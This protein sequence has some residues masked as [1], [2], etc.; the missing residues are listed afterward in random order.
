VGQRNLAV[1]MA[2]FEHIPHFQQEAWGGIVGGAV[3]F[4]GNE[5]ERELFMERQIRIAANQRVGVDVRV[6]GIPSAYQESQG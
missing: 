5:P 1:G 2:P 6:V 3:D 4:V